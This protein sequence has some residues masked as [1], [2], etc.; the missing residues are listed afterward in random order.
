MFES[1]VIVAYE[2]RHLLASTCLVDMG[3]MMLHL[4]RC[5]ET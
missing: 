3:Y 2:K 4:Q 1:S 5:V